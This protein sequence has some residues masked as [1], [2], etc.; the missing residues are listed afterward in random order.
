MDIGAGSAVLSLFAAKA[1]ARR[2]FAIEA[3]N[4]ATHARAL[5]EANG[6]EDVVS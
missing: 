6:Y 4:M 5:I 2:V 1:G 3:S